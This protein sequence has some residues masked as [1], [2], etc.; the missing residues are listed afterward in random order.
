M[1]ERETRELM[2]W[3]NSSIEM[4]SLIV[5]QMGDTALMALEDF[6]ALAINPDP[7]LAIAL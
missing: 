4:V 6:A 5:M 3:E 1:K 7:L 2:D